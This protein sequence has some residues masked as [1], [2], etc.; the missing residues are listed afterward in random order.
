[1]SS[2]DEHRSAM[3]SRFGVDRNTTPAFYVVLALTALAPI[4]GGCTAL[5]AEASLA[6]ATALLFF[7][8]PP[9]RSLGAVPNIVFGALV[10][11]TL[12][13]FLPARWFSLPDWRSVLEIMGARLPPT[14][15]A[16]PW[17][18]FQSTLQFFLGLS[19]SYY[20]LGADWSLPARK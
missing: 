2:I 6:A 11:L 18:T 19:W 1:M 8:A 17:L 4:L 12:V 20:L 14:V 13:A 10:M 16:Q 7:L 5:W 3:R 9:T 15:S